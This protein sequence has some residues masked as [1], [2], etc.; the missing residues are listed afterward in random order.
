[1]IETLL[2][3]LL[4]GSFRLL[5][6]LLKGLDRHL[7]RQHTLALQ[8]RTLAFAQLHDTETAEVPRHLQYPPPP[9]SPPYPSIPSPPACAPPSPTPSSCSTCA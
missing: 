2:G 5:P 9:A 1:M 6:E 8:D 3:G 7:E 4:G